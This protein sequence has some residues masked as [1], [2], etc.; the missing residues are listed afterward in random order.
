MPEY[1]GSVLFALMKLD[2]K[3]RPISVGDLFRRCCASLAAASIREPVTRLF[4]S[5]YKNFIQF[6][7]ISDGVSFCA[8]S[9]IAWYD[10]L[11]VVSAPEDPEVICALDVK[12][13]Y[14][15]TDRRLTLDVIN[16]EATRDYAAGFRKGQPFT[17]SS[18]ME[19]I[20]NLFPFWS[21]LRTVYSKSRY[22]D[23]SAKAHIIFG[24]SPLD[25]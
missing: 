16:N 22:F 5:S 19:A 3:I 17:T 21:S 23:Q 7:S 2:G 8:K 14:Q 24:K 12:S 1:A 18:H 11:D 6:A 10:T 15:C 20:T 4:Q 13:A 25:A 9:I